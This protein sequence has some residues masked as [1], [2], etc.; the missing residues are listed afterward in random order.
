MSL[1]FPI[2]HCA[3][4]VP[5]NC[6]SNYYHLTFVLWLSASAQYM[7]LFHHMRSHI[8]LVL[9][10]PFSLR[11]LSF[12]F[13]WVVEY[14]IYLLHSN[15]HLRL[16]YCLISG[17]NS[18]LTLL[19]L[20]PAIHH[21]YHIRSPFFPCWPIHILGFIYWVSYLLPHFFF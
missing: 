17:P 2:D 19:S 5:L 6:L 3:S 4:Q 16:I 8:I 18:A 20:L 21:L 7:H 1:V 11:I 9:A 14:V 13:V 12:P 15:L 10:V